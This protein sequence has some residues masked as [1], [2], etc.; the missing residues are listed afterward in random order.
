MSNDPMTI[1]YYEEFVAKA[2]EK[3]PEELAKPTTMKKV[4]EAYN[5]IAAS[6]AN[7]DKVKAK[8]YFAKTLAL[9]PTNN[10]ATESLK[11]LK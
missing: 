5:T 11:L 2:T 8:E 4:I 10:Y 1:K 9:D 6:Y 7:T 3:G